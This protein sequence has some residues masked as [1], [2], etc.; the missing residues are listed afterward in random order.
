MTKHTLGPWK[1]ECY[2]DGSF[3]IYA[4]KM[5]ISGRNPFETKADEM[6]ANAALISA[7]PELLDALKAIQ[8]AGEIPESMC[9]RLD[10][11][12]AKAEGE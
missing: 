9:D 3:D 2:L 12:I 11:I 7:A 6:K 8:A 5:I 10:A 1:A 4:D